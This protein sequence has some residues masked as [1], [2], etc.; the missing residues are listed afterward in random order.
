[1]KILDMHCDTI[2]CIYEQNQ[3][4]FQNSLHI[5]LS[6][7]KKYEGYAQFFAVFSDPVYKAAAIRRCLEIIDRL[8]LQVQQHDMYFCKSFADYEEAMQN[9]KVAAFLSL[10]GGEAIDSIAVLNNFY[11]LG[12]RCIALTWNY[13][14]HIATGV[15]EEKPE[16]GLTAFGRKMVARMNELGIITDVSHL[17]DR[18]FWD[19]AEV[20]KKPFIASH[21]NSRSV[22]SHRRNLTDEQFM[23]IVRAGGCVGINLYPLF[24]SDKKTAR[25]CDVLRHIE[26]FLSLG[27]ENN[28]GIGADFDGVDCLPEGIGGVHDMEKL[29]NELAKIGYS[30]SLLEKISS[31][32]FERIINNIL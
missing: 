6:R 13:S 18:A 32:N 11:R 22:C 17:S 25:I 24:L 4:L 26:H 2:T 7:V 19:V 21:S 30:D 12:V 23:E 14:N 31:K 5:D 28:I 3:N 1:M 15:L 8:Y 27:G 9:K 20:C 29:F 16:Y 10:E